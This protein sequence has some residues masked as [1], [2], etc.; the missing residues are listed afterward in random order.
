MCIM[1]LLTLCLI[2]SVLLIF[3]HPVDAGHLN[4]FAIGVVAMNMFIRIFPRQRRR[5]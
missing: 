2:V 3:T 1:V 4:A 5:V